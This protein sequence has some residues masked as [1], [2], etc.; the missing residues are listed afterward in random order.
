[1]KGGMWGFSP[2]YYIVTKVFIYKK[3]KSTQS[4]GSKIQNGENGVDLVIQH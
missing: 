1:M 4:E 2:V 3:K